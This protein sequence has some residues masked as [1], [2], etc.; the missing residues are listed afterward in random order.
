MSG[1]SG[2]GNI[3]KGLL[4]CGILLHIFCV[5]FHPIIS[6]VALFALCIPSLMCASYPRRGKEHRK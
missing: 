1:D 4:C 5:T 6:L 2:G 3:N